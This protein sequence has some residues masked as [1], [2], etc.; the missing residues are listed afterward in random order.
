MK[1]FEKTHVKV[2]LNTIYQVLG[3]FITALTGLIVTRMLTDQLGLEGFGNFQ[4]VITYVTIYWLL[5]DFGLNAVV[6]REMGENPKRESELFGSLLTMRTGLGLLLGL[7]SSLFLL[8]LP[9]TT[10]LKLAILIGMITFLTQGVIGSTH[11]LFQ[12]RLRYELLFF[13]NLISSLCFLGLMY[14][15]LQSTTN[16]I[17]LVGIF[18]AGQLINMAISIY[19]ASQLTNFHFNLDRPMLKKIAISTLPLGISLLLNLGNFKVDA[20]LLSVLEIP[21]HTNAEAVGIYNAAYK[22]FEFALIVPTFLMNAVYPIMI[23]AYE[24]SLTQF[25]Q[26]FWQA[27]AVL[28]IISFTGLGVG[29]FA[30]P[31]VISLVGDLSQFSSSVTTLRLLL[32]WTPVFFLS[33]LLMWTVLA[34]HLQRILVWIYGAAFILNL[35]L[36]LYLIPRYSFY[37]AAITTGLSE[38]LILVL[39]SYFVISHWRKNAKS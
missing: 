18:V 5:T 1:I 20:F 39:L 25:K 14:V 10:E 15:S 9:Y 11:G 33:G 8:F 2:G 23:R 31:W 16:I 34:F 22:F 19:F 13:A 26:I 35:T 24:K 36:N 21:M 38:V 28:T 7:V 12:N 30:A 32:L 6:V 17:Y 27:A 37:G 29:Y 3:R 4:I